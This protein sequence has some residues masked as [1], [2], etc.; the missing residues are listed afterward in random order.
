MRLVADVV[1]MRAGF[2]S[3]GLQ[4]KIILNFKKKVKFERLLV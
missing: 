2:F 3:F 1:T 4:T